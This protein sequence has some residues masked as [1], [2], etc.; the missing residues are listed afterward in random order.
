MAWTEEKRKA[1]A[2]RMRQNRLKK[3]AKAPTAVLERPE[4]D[5]LLGFKIRRGDQFHGLWELYKIGPEGPKQI[6]SATC[7]LLIMNMARNEI[8]GT[9]F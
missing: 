8:S 4:Y 2:E 6:G 3:F 7:K 9:T 1:A 5:L